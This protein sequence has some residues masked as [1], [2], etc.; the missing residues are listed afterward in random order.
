MPSLC[1]FDMLVDYSC[2]I[3]TT[4]ILAVE[5]ENDHVIR[6][7]YWGCDPHDTSSRIIFGQ[8]MVNNG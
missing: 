2:Q 7:Q 8:L 5:I 3:L 4:T 6:V 1:N